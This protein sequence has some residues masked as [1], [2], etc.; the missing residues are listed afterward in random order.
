MHDEVAAAPAPVVAG[1]L[2]KR[3]VVTEVMAG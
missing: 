3:V 2:A 1:L